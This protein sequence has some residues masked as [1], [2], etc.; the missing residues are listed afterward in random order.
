MNSEGLRVSAVV[1]LLRS[2]DFQLLVGLKKKKA[3]QACVRLLI[4]CVLYCIDTVLNGSPLLSGR[5]YFHQN[6]LNLSMCGVFSR[7][8]L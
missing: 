2:V 5:E 3:L 1:N 6:L 8:D 7:C 4:A